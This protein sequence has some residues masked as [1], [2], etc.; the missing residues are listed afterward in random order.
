MADFFRFENRTMIS[1]TLVMETPISV[2]NRT[3]LLPA[4]SDLP[5]I[6]TPGGIPFIPGSSLKGAIRAYT[7]RLLRTL[8][9]T[10]K[11]DVCPRGNY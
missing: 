11:S 10:G 8:D 4:G 6:K 5:V 3:S 1:A 9:A 7:E 2:G